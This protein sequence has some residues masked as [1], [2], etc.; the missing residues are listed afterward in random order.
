MRFLG[1]RCVDITILNS[2]KPNLNIDDTVVK[3]VDKSNL[4][5]DCTSIESK[6]DN[7]TSIFVFGKKN[8]KNNSD[9]N[10]SEGFN[11]VFCSNCVGPSSCN[12]NTDSNI[13]ESSRVKYNFSNLFDN[14]KKMEPKLENEIK[15]QLDLDNNETSI[16]NPKENFIK[17]KE[18]NNQ[19]QSIDENSSN[20][21]VVKII[22]KEFK[23]VIS[24]FI[25]E[26]I[27]G[28]K[29]FA[30]VEAR[31]TILE[32]QVQ[33]LRTTVPKESSSISLANNND[34]AKSITNSASQQPLCQSP[35]LFSHQ[36]LLPL[37]PSP[38]ESSTL[39]NSA[40]GST[41]SLFGSSSTPFI[42]GTSTG[43]STNTFSSAASSVLDNSN[44][45]SS[46]L[47]VGSSA[48]DPTMATKIP[49]GSQLFGISTQTAK[50]TG[51]SMAC[52][53][54]KVHKLFSHEAVTD[55]LNAQKES[56]MNDFSTRANNEK[57]FKKVANEQNNL[58]LKQDVPNKEAFELH[59][60]RTIQ[61]S[62]KKA[63]E[64]YWEHLKSNTSE[65][66]IKKFNSG[67]MF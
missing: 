55:F 37:V 26:R 32:E 18:S 30:Q 4:N 7:K 36:T 52:E 31:I 61:M 46:N 40:F 50:Q 28:E 45:T 63:M 34:T 13:G 42:N 3:S 62:V 39:Q 10:T 29:K 21:E 51:K 49:G 6:S 22:V 38:A 11:F 14:K 58:E 41:S 20:R 57:T 17:D 16:D 54:K 35:V 43:T 1:K 65:S 44:T 47:V 2:S 15:A 56:S 59:L 66:N 64:E 48:F 33:N 67:N 24:S 27:E 25:N 19:D 23:N 12:S 5:T 8:E 9:L 53:R 60:Q